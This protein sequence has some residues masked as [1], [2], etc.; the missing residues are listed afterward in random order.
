MQGSRRLDLRRRDLVM[1]IGRVRAMN[2]S[3]PAA[4]ARMTATVRTYRDLLVWRKALDLADLCYHLTERFPREELFGLTA[5]IRRCATSV[6]AN[7]AEGRGRRRTKEFLQFLRI[8]HESLKE[9][10]THFEI[11]R[12]RGYLSVQ[13]VNRVNLK[14]VEIG[15]MIGELRRR[16]RHR[17]KSIDTRR[18][19][20]DRTE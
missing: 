13:E 12:R 7:I 14:S 2:A 4:K 8:S 11:A 3:I 20:G 15:R 6:P 16:L 18:E 9:F 19:R 5:Q 1:G 17:L 10:E